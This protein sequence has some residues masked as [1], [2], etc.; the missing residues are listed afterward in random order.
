MSESG[1]HALDDARGVFPN[2]QLLIIQPFYWIED[3]TGEGLLSTSP[4]GSFLRL[5]FLTCL[6]VAFSGCTEEP[7]AAPAQHE[8][9]SNNN[10]SPTVSERKPAEMIPSIAA[11]SE[12]AARA[13]IDFTYHNGEESGHFAILESLGGGVGMFDYDNDSDVDLFVPGGGRYESEKKVVG[14]SPGL[15]RNHG[16]WRFSAETDAAGV[17][18][19]PWLFQSFPRAIFK[20]Y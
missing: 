8:S 14:L 19:A 4:I 20:A 12:T 2:M 9:Q 1:D 3:R 11:F 13:G 16:D 6:V 5:C 10:R 17:A 15:F 18:T 7:P